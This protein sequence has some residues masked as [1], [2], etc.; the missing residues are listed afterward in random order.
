MGCESR[1]PPTINEIGPIVIR[2]VCGA[3]IDLGD[4]I[5]PPGGTK[6]VPYRCLMPGNRVR[7]EFH[8]GT[9]DIVKWP[10][11]FDPV[12]YPSSATMY[13]MPEGWAKRANAP[14]DSRRES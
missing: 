9:I 13:R 10:E 4:L 12:S 11:G 1:K 14:I 7:T 6:R 2:N 5:L 3:E 8:R